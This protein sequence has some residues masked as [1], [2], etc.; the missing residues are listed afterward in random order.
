VARSTRV[1]LHGGDALRLDLL[2]IYAAGDVA[3]D[4]GDV[5]LVAQR[6]DGGQDG[7]RLART[8]AGKQVEHEHVVLGETLAQFGGD[9]IVLL[10]DRLLQID[11]HG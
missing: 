11:L 5:E 7:G 10:E 2:G 4:N 8:G 3:L 6:V 9:R 1:D